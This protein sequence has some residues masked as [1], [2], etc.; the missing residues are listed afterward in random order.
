MTPE[1]TI[2][3]SKGEIILSICFIGFYFLAVLIIGH[4]SIYAERKTNKKYN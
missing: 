2:Q 1:Q 4:W 3:L